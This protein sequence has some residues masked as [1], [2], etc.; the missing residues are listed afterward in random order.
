MLP[1]ALQ[2]GVGCLFCFRWCMALAQL[3]FEIAKAIGCTA[4]FNDLLSQ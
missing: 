1:D 3:S 2:Q 4:S